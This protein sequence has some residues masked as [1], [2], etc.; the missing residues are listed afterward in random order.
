M[1]LPERPP[2]ERIQNILD[3]RKF[4]SSQGDIRDAIAR[5]FLQLCAEIDHLRAE[6]LDYRRVS[7]AHHLASCADTVTL[8]TC[9][10]VD[11]L[12]KRARNG[13]FDGEFEKR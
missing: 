7:Y 10:E 5:D 2:A 11:D 1:T 12:V 8:L 13:E 3:N 4:L 9:D 6:L